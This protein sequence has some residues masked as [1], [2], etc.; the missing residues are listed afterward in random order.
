MAWAK[1][2]DITKNLYATRDY[3]TWKFYYSGELVLTV[4]NIR[5]RVALSILDDIYYYTRLKAHDV[6]T[7]KAKIKK[8]VPK[9]C[10]FDAAE[11]KKSRREEIGPNHYIFR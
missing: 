2:I 6:E 9:W 4:E 3:R 11:K 10:F 5:Y 7:V 1:R 8:I